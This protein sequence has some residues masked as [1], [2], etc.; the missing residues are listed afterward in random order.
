MLGCVDGCTEGRV[1]KEEEVIKTSN[2]SI[3]FEILAVLTLVACWDLMRVG[4]SEQ[5]IRLS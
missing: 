1:L 3:V 2:S 5:D 4:R